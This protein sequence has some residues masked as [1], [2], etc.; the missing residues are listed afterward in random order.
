MVKKP[1]VWSPL[2]LYR[3]VIIIFICDLLTLSDLLCLISAQICYCVF[4]TSCSRTSSVSVY[5]QYSFVTCSKSLFFVGI[6]IAVFVWET[7]LESFLSW[8]QEATVEFLP[9]LDDRIDQEKVFEGMWVVV[10]HVHVYIFWCCRHCIPW[11]V[12]LQAVYTY[13]VLIGY[14]VQV[15]CLLLALDLCSQTSYLFFRSE[16]QG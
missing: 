5:H 11:A 7:T 15:H 12:G 13:H 9:P 2:G 14:T 16:C 10:A 4:V 1:Q 8:A 6:Q 3:H